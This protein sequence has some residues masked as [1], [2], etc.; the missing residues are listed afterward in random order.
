MRQRCVPIS[1]K[2]RRGNFAAE[3]KKSPEEIDK[4]SVNA[5]GHICRA[6]GT[7]ADRTMTGGSLPGIHLA[8]APGK[9]ICHQS[10]ADDQNAK[11]S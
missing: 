1:G 7:D 6:A 10:C 9:V 3:I 2:R 4:S 5:G 11:V 8:S